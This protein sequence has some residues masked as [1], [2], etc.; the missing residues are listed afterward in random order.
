MNNLHSHGLNELVLNLKE[1]EYNIGVSRD[2]APIYTM[3]SKFN[4]YEKALTVV[5]VKHSPCDESISSEGMT[6]NTALCCEQQFDAVRI[7]DIVLTGNVRIIRSLG[8]AEF[9]VIADKMI[10]A[11]YIN[12]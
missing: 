4:G 7:G 5:H 9:N 2:M 12:L 6:F 11:K 3:G 1:D 8:V 10:V